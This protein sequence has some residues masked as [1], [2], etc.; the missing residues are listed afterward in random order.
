MGKKNRIYMY[1]D[2]R[3]QWRWRLVAKNNKTIAISSE[4]YHN[5]DDCLH[6]IKLVLD[7]RYSENPIINLVRSSTV[8]IIDT[9][10]YDDIHDA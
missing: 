9:G 10:I 8:E 2:T 7:L 3:S 4:G 6:A 5:Y 1:K